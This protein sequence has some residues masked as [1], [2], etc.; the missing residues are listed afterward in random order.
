MADIDKL[1]ID[2]IIQ[3]LLEGEV[4]EDL[5]RELGAAAPLGRHHRRRLTGCPG[6]SPPGAGSPRPAPLPPIAA[7]S[8]YLHAGP[9]P[10]ALAS[11]PLAPAARVR[12]LGLGSPSSGAGCGIHFDVG[13]RLSWR[14]GLEAC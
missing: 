5:R 9:R 2:S 1:N 12:A 13:V 6:I 10:S 14:V 7:L 11:P 4:G 8:D 3:R